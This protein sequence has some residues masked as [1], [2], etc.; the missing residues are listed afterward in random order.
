MCKLKAVGSQLV[1]DCATDFIEF[2]S[3]ECVNSHFKA[4]SMLLEKGI[5]THK[6]EEEITFDLSEE[7][8]KIIW[9][10]LEVAKEIE[11]Q[12]YNP[13][14]FG[15]KDDDGFPIRQKTL[16]SI[17]EALFQNPLLSVQYINNYDEPEP[18][19]GVYMEG[20][21]RFKGLLELLKRKII[22]T[23]MYKLT[24]KMGDMREVFIGMMGLKSMGFVSTLILE[25][26]KEATPIQDPEANYDL[27]Y[28][29][30]AQVY[31]LPSSEANLYIHENPILA[32]LSE[33]LKKM[34]KKAIAADMQPKPIDEAMDYVTLYETKMLEYRQRFMNEAG[35][36]GIAITPPE[37]LVM[38][39][40]A[41]SWTVGLGAP[42][43]NMALDRNNITDVYI[44][45]ENSPIYIEHAK[46]GL[47]HTLWRYN[48]E[49]M[50]HLARNIMATSKGRKFDEKHPVV[51]VFLTRLNMRCHLQGP[52]ATFGEIQAALRMTKESPFT[53]AQYLYHHSMSALAAGYD[54]IMVGLGCS[55]AVLGL[56]G[57]GKTAFTAAKIVAIGTKRRILPIQ[58]IEEIPTKTY[59]K[60]GFHIGAM[61]VMSSDREEEERGSELSLISMA[62][63]SLRMGD[64]AL[65]INEVRSKTS[66]QGIINLLNTQPGVFCLYNLHA[67][68]LKDIQ[69][70]LELV[71]NVPAA[72]MYATDRYS[73]LKKIR[74][75]RKGRVYRLLGS[76]WETD[77][78]NKS[79]AEIFNFERTGGSIEKCRVACKFLE[80]PEANLW[81]LSEV[82]IAQLAKELKM[83]FV[84][85]AL[86]R[87][88]QETGIPPEQYILQ[89]FFKGKMYSQILHAAS[90]RK[91]SELLEIDFV[92]KCSSESNNLMKQ[93]ETE[94]GTVDYREL[95]KAWEAK[96]KTLLDAELRILEEEERVRKT[97]FESGE[98][99][100]SQHVESEAATTP[101]GVLPRKTEVGL[102]KFT[103]KND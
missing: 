63:A 54:D 66:I 24:E 56:K 81:D 13:D 101:T 95:E 68:S 85:P 103:K 33:P 37:A 28:G 26:P 92:L 23:D 55:E 90:E 38:G 64:S 40:E 62:G 72:S 21:M 87:R 69:D 82:N 7:N 41:A 27:G 43:E 50:E 100:P 53:Y 73:F 32:N 34:L 35:M 60:R 39:R 2:L 52:P 99:A 45:S 4:I 57:V 96:F 6:Y 10:Y 51:D 84:P 59:R 15:R 91:K 93:M 77:T 30:R 61:K 31:D 17:Q 67:Q 83:R 1:M 71:F 102:G 86:A 20:Y 18:E 14:T 9:D 11:V 79:F 94:E 78:E 36:Q 8:T 44:D 89:A 29:V 25:K 88:A 12:M 16:R 46:F 70:R 65:I 5:K 75:G 98:L 97:S 80:N 19:R 47:C 58:D 22:S 76:M 3:P 42:I 49:L 48:R 74:F